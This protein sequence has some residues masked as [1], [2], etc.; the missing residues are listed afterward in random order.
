[1]KIELYQAET[2]KTC[3]FHQSILDDVSARL[4]QKDTLS[5]LETNGVIHSLQVLIENAIGKAKHLLKFH[6]KSIP[7]S[8]HDAF[9]ALKNYE[10]ISA[11][12]LSNWQKIIG[13]RNTIVHEYM[14]V[15]LELVNKIVINKEYQI[16]IDFL[17][18]PF[19]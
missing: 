19:I 12:E 4:K 9:E 8:G 11:N 10:L 13:F 15:N 6:G 1:M 14:N 7:V 18:K 16:I 3:R 2:E 17:M 5:D